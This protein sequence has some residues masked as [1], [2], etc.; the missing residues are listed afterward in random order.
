MSAL[1][2]KCAEE[3]SLGNYKEANSTLSQLEEMRLAEYGLS[4]IVV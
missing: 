3:F 4:R 2:E 1:F